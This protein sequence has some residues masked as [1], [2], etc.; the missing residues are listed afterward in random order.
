MLLSNGL[1]FKTTSPNFFLLLHRVIFPLFVGLTC[2]FSIASLPQI[3]ILSYSQINPSFVDKMS[4]S[5]CLKVNK[6][7][8][9][10]RQGAL[11]GEDCMDWSREEV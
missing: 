3:A 9:D 7:E 2:G 1:L 8:E 5:F 4:G 10:Q 6:R 11:G